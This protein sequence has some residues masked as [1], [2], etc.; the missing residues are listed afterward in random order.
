MKKKKQLAIHFI[1]TGGTIDSFYN[2]RV[3]TVKP[4][5]K[6]VI[7]E[8]LK[9]LHL[10]IKTRFT[11]ICMKDSR[12]LTLKD[13]RDIYKTIEKSKYKY[14]V[15]T[16]GTY[17]MP[18]TGRYLQRYLK[19]KNKVVV[20]TGS[21]VPLEAFAHSDASFNLGFTIAE[22]LHLGP[23]IYI[24]MN[25]KIFSPDEIA[26]LISQGKFVSIFT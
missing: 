15:I 26:K 25:G 16:H 1:L 22:I 4:L 20:L 24:C 9:R 14:F 3:D 8:Y 13:M 2:G 6:S 21:L 5:K 7:P 10:N 11:Q 17:S 23:G 19:D 12:D 18:D